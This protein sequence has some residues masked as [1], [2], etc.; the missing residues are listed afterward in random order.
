MLR[1][2]IEW[3]GNE[4]NSVSG[5]RAERNLNVII[6]RISWLGNKTL[7]HHVI[8]ADVTP[9]AADEPM[10]ERGA[11][12]GWRPAQKVA[13]CASSVA[14]ERGAFWRRVERRR[15]RARS[16]INVEHAAAST[17]LAWTC[18]RRAQR[19]F[20]LSLVRSLAF[21]SIAAF[22]SER[23]S[24]PRALPFL[25]SDPAS[26]VCKRMTSR[27]SNSVVVVFLKFF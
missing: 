1:I 23:K 15:R 2:R 13:D 14:R 9:L 27:C 4:N 22:S 18:D 19:F 21:F 6:P 7:S 11:G 3:H 24:R 8:R 5:R 12:P 20:S 25:L 10:R 26:F 16:S 17:L